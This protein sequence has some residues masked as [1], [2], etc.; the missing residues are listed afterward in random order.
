V[1]IAFD[2]NLTSTPYYASPQLDNL[3]FNTT[4]AAASG[5]KIFL[6][7]S[8]FDGLG[9]A[10]PDV[11]GG[12]LTWSW[13]FTTV[14]GGDK[15][16]LYVADAPTGLPSGSTISALWTEGGVNAHAA[17]ACSFTGLATG[18]TPDQNSATSS[19][20][21]SW[22]GG[23]LNTTVPA[24]LI[25]ACGMVDGS[26]PAFTPG[27]GYTEIHDWFGAADNEAWETIYRITSAPGAYNPTG[28][29]GSGVYC[30]LSVSYSGPLVRD[31]LPIAADFPSTHF[32]PF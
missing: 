27:A 30:G 8:W 7:I 2:A 6:P 23:T 14:N 10:S 19:G 13:I 9:L 5:A 20:T 11:S 32:G 31:P 26:T 22:S 12:G 28:V 16:A 25:F 24:S 3:S 15:M 29:G 17:S 18:S 1:P 4:A 21:T